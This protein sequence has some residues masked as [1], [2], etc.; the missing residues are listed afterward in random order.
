MPKPN[1]YNGDGSLKPGRN[2]GPEPHLSALHTDYHTGQYVALPEAKGGFMKV[3]ARLMLYIMIAAMCAA[4]LGGLTGCQ[5]NVVNV[6]HSD[7][8][9]VVGE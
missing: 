4:L 6:V 1:K 7:L 5:V 3:I 9:L 8:G 2:V